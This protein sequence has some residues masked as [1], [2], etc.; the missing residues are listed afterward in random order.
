MCLDYVYVFKS[1]IVL[2][3]ESL[4]FNI[5]SSRRWVLN[6]GKVNWMNKFRD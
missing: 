4:G 3:F 1:L 6:F 5:G 2:D